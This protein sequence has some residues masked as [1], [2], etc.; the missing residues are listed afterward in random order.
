MA[1]IRP[2]K[3]APVPADLHAVATPDLYTR[4]RLAELERAMSEGQALV[5]AS[6]FVGDEEDLYF[7]RLRRSEWSS[8]LPRHV[9]TAGGEMSVVGTPMLS[10][11][12]ELSRDVQTITEIVTGLVAA[13]RLGTVYEAEAHLAPG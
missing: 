8:R 12:Q 4:E 1:G 11:S 3:S 10:I 5:H 2:V 6:R 7:W 13:R 9:A